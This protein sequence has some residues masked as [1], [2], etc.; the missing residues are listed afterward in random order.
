MENEILTHLNQPQQLEK[1]YRQNKSA[2]K[3]AFSALYPEL[4]DNSLA[5]FWHERLHYETDE[6]YWGT[7]R[8]LQFVIIAALVAGI[9]AKIPAIFSLDEEF[10]Y[11]RNIGFIV[12][13]LLTT[14][15]ALKSH[16]EIRK[17]ALIIGVT[18]ISLIY[19]NFLPNVKNS[20][21]LILS[22]IH[23]ILLLWAM[24]GFA[25]VGNQPGNLQKRLS[26]LRYNGD[27]LVMCALLLISGG[28][29]TGITIN[30]FAII[31]YKIEE[32][33]F[34]Y[35]VIMGLAA[36]PIVGTYITQTNPQLVNKIS[37]VIARLFSP[38][39]LITL[40]GYLVAI[41]T[42]GKDPYNDREFLIIFNALLVGVM[43]IILFSVAESA[44]NSQRQ[45]EIIIL[46]LLSVVTVIVNGIALS[47]ILFRI[48]EWGIT[49]NRAAVMG[50][51]IL[52]LINLLLVAIKLWQVIIRKKDV[53]EVGK[54]IAFFLP[55]YACWAII[56]TFIFPVIFGFK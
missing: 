37:P 1:L 22:C 54:S 10:F 40:V 42:S 38:L 16:L 39:V 21:T 50:S 24:L 33:Y 18:V 44:K 7:R 20:D 11:P 3:K 9:L 34:Q 23:L 13:P 45:T 27:L 52:I 17:T 32:I 31:G 36:L 55:V 15:F 2:F 19:I 4:S 28:I 51:N 6:I 43:A 8:D 48:S 5:Q 56:V 14:Y 53:S 41:I 35:V 47:A 12:F 49:P 30:L 25:Y 46:F 29:L 26:F